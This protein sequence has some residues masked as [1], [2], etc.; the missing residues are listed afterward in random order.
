MR[1]AIKGISKMKKKYAQ[2]GV[3]GRSQMF[4]NSIVDRFKEDCELLGICDNNAGR[5]ARCAE[6]LRELG[7]EVKTY[8]AESF[9]RMIAECNP[10][11]VI[12]TT[13]DC[14]HH[15]YICRAMELGCDALTEKP[16]TTDADKCQQI[17]DTEKRTGR[18]CTV[19]FNYRYAPPHTQLK[20]LL[21]SGLIGNVISVDFHWMLNTSHG[22]DYFRRWHRNKENSGGLMVHK[23][24]HH[25]DLVNWWLSTVP[26]RVFA[27]G[28]RNYYVP[29]TADRYGLKNRGERCHG[30]PESANC[31]FFLDMAGNKG[32]TE[33]YLDH[34]KHDGYLRDRC[35][36]SPEIDI[37]DTMN[38]VVDYRSGATMSYSLNAFSPWEG[39][40]VTF[41]GSRGRIEHVHEETVY[42]NGDGKVPGE[43]I[44]TGTHTKVFPHFLPAYEVDLWT[45]TGGH[46]GGDTA[47]LDDLFLPNPPAD[48][49][50]RAADHRAGAWSIITGI[51][52]NRSFDSKQPVEIKDYLPELAEPDY[53]TMPKP[54]EPI[55][56]ADLDAIKTERE[57]RAA[58]EAE[59]KE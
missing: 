43:L 10:D 32:L 34:E 45:G 33:L 23:A 55:P 18:K 40:T 46:G 3:G 7:V 47:L 31:P 21:M 58:R 30:C 12:V 53:P 27:T 17:L 6:K 49:Y 57:N 11:T 13:R 39:F 29:E 25:F 35:V 26:E 37:E 20:E 48:K 36:F 28:N 5:L 24:T 2:V 59:K 38:V 51:A 14:H 44:E 50:K 52:A 54:F 4:W 22:A 9:D 19:S 15:E 1:A 8:D 56:A 42:I 41:N 16:M